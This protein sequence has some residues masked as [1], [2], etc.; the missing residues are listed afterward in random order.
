[1]LVRD[2]ST[3]VPLAANGEWKARTQYWTRRLRDG[4]VVEAQAPS[5]GAIAIP[6]SVQ[7]VSF[8]CCATC[9][10]QAACET[11]GRCAAQ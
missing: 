9:L 11:V 6:P 10:K 8:V 4:D 3:Q 2:P 1:M 5:A 7:P